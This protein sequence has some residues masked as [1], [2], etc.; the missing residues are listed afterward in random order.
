MLDAGG[1]IGRSFSPERQQTEV[2]LFK[3]LAD[4][5]N[6]T[7]QETQ[8]VIASY[9]DGA[10][11]RLTGLIEDEGLADARPIADFRDMPASAPAACS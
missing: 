6:A 2:S 4:H 9:S 5:I 7:R 1:R 3:A 10:R 11:E 8:V